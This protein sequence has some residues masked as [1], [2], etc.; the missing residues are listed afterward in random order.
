[1][2]TT[3]AVILLAEDDDNDVFFM[4]RALQKARI[5]FQLQVVTNGQHALDYLS[6]EGKFADRNAYPLPSIILLDLKM[7][8]LDGFEVLSWIGEQPSL[9]K[10]PVAVLTSSAEER[11]RRRAAELGAKAYFVKPPKPETIAEISRIIDEGRH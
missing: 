2:T 7:P 11:D 8:F 10:I 6:G 5:E 3:H 9:K 4:R 1:M